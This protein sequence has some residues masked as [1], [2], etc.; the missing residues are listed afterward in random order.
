M[1][2]NY[3]AEGVNIY[4]VT[5]GQSSGMQATC[6]L[7]TSCRAAPVA[8]ESGELLV[9]DRRHVTKSADSNQR[10]G[11][12]FHP[13]TSSIKL[14]PRGVILPSSSSLNVASADA[15][16]GT[17]VGCSLLLAGSPENLCINGL[18]T[19]LVNAKSVTFALLYDR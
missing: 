3:D 2:Y 9:R 16:L 17:D 10:L 14:T 11:F 6:M 1:E 19:V 5:Q 7:D 12:F 8:R 4:G 18:W 13:S 15:R